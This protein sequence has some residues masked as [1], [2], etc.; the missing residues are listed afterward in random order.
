MTLW[1][2]NK[3]GVHASCPPGYNCLGGRQGHDLGCLEAVDPL[4]AVRQ[5]GAH[6]RL[7]PT[8]VCDLPA[9]FAAANTVNS[10][11]NAAGAL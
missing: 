3:I 5:A 1:N 7:L 2:G 6:L 11:A 10:A 4:A 9:T 8:A